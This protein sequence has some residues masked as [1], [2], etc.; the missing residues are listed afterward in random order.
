MRSRLPLFTPHFPP[1]HRSTPNDFHN[2]GRHEKTCAYLAKG[3]SRRML[4]LG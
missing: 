4:N 3:M 1:F 2:A